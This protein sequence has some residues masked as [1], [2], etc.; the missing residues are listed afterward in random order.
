LD[1]KHLY[2]NGEDAD[3]RVYRLRADDGTVETLFA[4]RFP[5]E[6]RDGKRILYA[7][8]FQFGIFARSLEGDPIKN[9]EQRLVDDYTPPL[10]GFFPV[11]N[12]F[13]YTSFSRQGHASALRFFE[14]A[15]GKATDIAP[16]PQNLNMG[17]AV[18]PDQRWL[19]YSAGE[20]S[21][22]YDLLPG[23]GHRSALIVRK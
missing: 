11:E 18:S 20:E 10:G 3:G 2:A 7:K 8:V 21:S 9:P 22:G 12:G 14:Y 1:G 23:Y 4:G 13:F 5:I 19:L 15:S 6:T 17:L 16:A